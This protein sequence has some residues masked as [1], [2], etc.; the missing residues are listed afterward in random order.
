MGAALDPNCGV[1]NEVDAEAEPTSKDMKGIGFDGL[2][3]NGAVGRRCVAPVGPG[4]PPAGKITGGI[5]NSF[6]IGNWIS[7]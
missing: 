3:W 1:E 7:R 6:D 5:L 4:F 2:G